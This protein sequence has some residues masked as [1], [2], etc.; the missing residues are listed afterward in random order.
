[1]KKNNFFTIAIP[2]KNRSSLLCETL[3]NI[4]LQKGFDQIN[5]IICDNSSNDDTVLVLQRYEK[6][7]NI[8]IIYNTEPLSIDENMIKVASYVESDYFLWLGDDDMLK[9]N[10]LQNLISIIKENL[11]DFILLNATFVSADLLTSF[12]NTMDIKSNI[13]YN[14]PKDFFNNHYSQTPFG[15]LI[16]KTELLRGSLS[17]VDKYNDTSHAYGGIVLDYLATKYQKTKHVSILVI[18]HSYIMLRSVPKSWIL[19]S[20]QIYFQH[21][22]KYYDVL[23]SQY[24]PKSNEIKI[25]YIKKLFSF[26]YLIYYRFLTNINLFNFKANTLY[27]TPIMKLKYIFAVMI[28]RFNFIKKYLIARSDEKVKKF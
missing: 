3:D 16:V 25:D 17:G 21:I 19:E 8:E 14:S 1:M 5:V 2:T 18:A 6:Y 27:A 26:K 24:A 15:T 10:Q 7:S 22:P 13:H 28:P 23:D 9:E 20:T 4:I 11:S 12:N